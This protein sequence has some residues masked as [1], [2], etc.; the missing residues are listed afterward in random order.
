M[1]QVRHLALDSQPAPHGAAPP[2]ADEQRAAFTALE[3]LESLRLRLVDGV[4]ALLAHLHHMPSL[5]LLTIECIP[6]D[7][8]PAAQQHPSLV[9]LQSLLSA[10][11]L[12]SVRLEGPPS[13][14]HW[15]RDRPRLRLQQNGHFITLE[16]DS[17]L[18]AA[19]WESL[20]RMAQELSP[21]VIWMPV[22]SEPYGV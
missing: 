16:D 5:R 3:R 8:V 18:F 7:P 21:R 6:L 11:L 15:L 17:Q 13:L 12:L 2:S 1:R 4:D 19:Q 10:A 22:P 20:Q 14:A 9:A